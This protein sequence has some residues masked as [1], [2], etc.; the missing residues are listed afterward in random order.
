MALLYQFN[1]KMGHRKR[2][3]FF[4]LWRCDWFA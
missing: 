3:C 1:Y 2:S 4:V